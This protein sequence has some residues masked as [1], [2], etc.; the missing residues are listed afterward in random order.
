[1]QPVLA[2]SCV[3]QSAEDPLSG[4]SVGER[5]PPEV[6]DG[7]DQPGQ[8]EFLVRG[9]TSAQQRRRL[10]RVVVQIDAV[11]R[12]A[13]RHPHTPAGVQQVHQLLDAAQFHAPVLP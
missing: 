8:L 2:V 9:A 3:S 1:M 13:R 10:Q 12:P 7:V 11:G 5:P 6:P 4:L